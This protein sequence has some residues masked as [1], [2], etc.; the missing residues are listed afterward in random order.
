[1][2]C[3]WLSILS[4]HTRFNLEGYRASCF[5]ETIFTGDRWFVSC[6]GCLHL[7]KGLFYRVVPADQD[8]QPEAG[9]CG[10]FR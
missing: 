9:Y 2:L 7:T 1:M 5:M 8:F 4:I 3:C 6:L 10:V